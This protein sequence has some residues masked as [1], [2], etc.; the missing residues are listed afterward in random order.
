MI[1]QIF[2]NQCFT[3]FITKILLSGD[4]ELNQEPNNK[5]LVNISIFPMSI[6]SL[7]AYEFNKILIESC[8]T[9]HKFD[10]ACLSFVYKQK[11]Q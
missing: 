3:Y 9:V 6:N 4:I 5:N 8:L 10:L 7:T 11:R 2:K 1:F